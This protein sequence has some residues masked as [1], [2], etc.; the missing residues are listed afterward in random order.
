MNKVLLIM[1]VIS[2]SFAGDL[3][4]DNTIKYFD[5]MLLN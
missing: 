2:T 4:V 1:F 5:G 3:S